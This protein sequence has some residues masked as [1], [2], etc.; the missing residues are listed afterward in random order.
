[1]FQNPGCAVEWLQPSPYTWAQLRGSKVGLPSSCPFN[2]FQKLLVLNWFQVETTDLHQPDPTHAEQQVAHL[3]DDPA[4]ESGQPSPEIPVSLP[5]ETVS[6][7]TQDRAVVNL[8]DVALVILVAFFSI[9]LCTTI[10]IAI[11][12]SAHG[13]HQKI[14]DVVGNALVILP[15]QFAAYLMIVGFMVFLVRARHRT[16]FREGIQW[17][18]PDRRT[19]LSALAGGAGLALA[20]Q[21][22]SGLLQRWTPKSLPIEQYFKNAASGYALALFG[23]F[24]APLVEELF[25]RGFLYPAL[26]RW[27][28]VSVAVVLTAAS[29]SLLH[30]AQLADAWAPL[31]I[32]FGVGAVLTVVRVKMRSVAGSVFV[33]MGYNATL[34][35]IMF[36]YTQG[37]RHMEKLS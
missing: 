1:M 24:V 17:N 27:T 31:L 19:A 25:F 13:A 23:I 5:A 2:F 4:S 12:Y 34:F 22:F 30:G 28:G 32:I 6:G 14:A 10:A 15:A 36:I 9:F 29:F 18:M 3:T 37:F 7:I 33:H 26:E 8:G 21:L 16:G 11:A 20:S 35:T